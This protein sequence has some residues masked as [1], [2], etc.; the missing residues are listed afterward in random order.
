MQS[1]NHIIRLNQTTIK[2]WA[3]GQYQKAIE[4]YFSIN[5]FTSEKMADGKNFHK[6][7]REH[8]EQTK[9]L[10]D[11]FGGKKLNNPICE[12]TYKVM[13][14]SW[15]ELYGTPDMHDSPTLHEYKSGKGSSE[16]YASDWQIRIYAVLLTLPGVWIDEN[17]KEHTHEGILIERAEVHTYDQYAKKPGYSEVWITDQTLR[18]TQNYIET[19]A[20][21]MFNYFDQ[22]D[23]WNKFG[24][25]IKKYTHE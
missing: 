14:T 12:R 20:G 6:I 10:P 25:L 4:H 9:T 16:N 21:E 1:S 5:N 23:I 7:W 13:V 19:I 11:I 2:A 15:L 8:V 24:H 3:S 18:D 17:E 22:N